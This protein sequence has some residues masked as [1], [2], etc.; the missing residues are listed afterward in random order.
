MK[1]LAST[2]ERF[3]AKLIDW[4]LQAFPLVTLLSSVEIIVDGPETRV[5]FIAPAIASIMLLCA[6][7]MLMQWTLI[8]MR[9]QSIGKVI[10]RLQ[11]VD[12]KTKKV[13]SVWNV[14]FVRTLINGIMLGNGVYFLMDA[15]MILRKEQRCIH[16]FIANTIVIKAK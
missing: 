14:L 9:G 5:A 13:P 8:A 4:A 6:A 10:M 3:F 11:I 16:D 1:K 12:Q 7:F 2:Q 15:L